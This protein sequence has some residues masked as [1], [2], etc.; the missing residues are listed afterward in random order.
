MRMS[1]LVRIT[2]VRVLQGRCV[3]LWLSDGRDKD[4]DLTPLLR[5]PVFEPLLANDALFAAV[6]VDPDFGTLVWPNGADLCPDVLIH[7]REPA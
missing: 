1:S 3:R 7:D 6:Q 2:G 5:G 4:V